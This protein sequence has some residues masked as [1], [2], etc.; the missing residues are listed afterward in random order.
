MKTKKYVTDPASRLYEFWELFK[1]GKDGEVYQLAQT[2]VPLYQNQRVYMHKNKYGAITMHKLQDEGF[3]YES[4][5]SN[6][7]TPFSAF[8]GG[9]F[10][11]MK[12]LK[13]RIEIS[14]D[15]AVK[16]ITDYETVI[17]V[18]Q[19]GKEYEISSPYFDFEDMDVVDFEDMSKVM[20]YKESN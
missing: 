5:G 14:I 9:K 4:A 10:R 20:F 11:R 13:E 19:N 6:L 12:K 1:Y 2:N 3:D 8:T 7:I 18:K 16:R 17:A 15:E